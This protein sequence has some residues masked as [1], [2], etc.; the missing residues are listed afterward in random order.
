MS[1]DTERRQSNRAPRPRVEWLPARVPFQRG[2]SAAVVG[3]TADLDAAVK[4]EWFVRAEEVKRGE[5]DSA[6]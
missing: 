1:H 6:R 4:H 2:S 5:R 3:Y